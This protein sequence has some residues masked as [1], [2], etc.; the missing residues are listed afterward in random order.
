MKPDDKLLVFFEG[1]AKRKGD[2]MDAMQRDELP[3][4][5]FIDKSPPLEA[6]DFLAW[7][8]LHAIKTGY[9]MTPILDD[10]MGH[11]PGDDGIYLASDLL[12]LATTV[13][14]PAPLRS[15][16]SPNAKLYHRSSPKR[17]RRRTIF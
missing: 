10:L 16:L 1:G 4:P 5:S 11:H 14:V 17:P 12:K 8:L 3:C 7:E 15:H 9:Q 2:F 13:P 6:A